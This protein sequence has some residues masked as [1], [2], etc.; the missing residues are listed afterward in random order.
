MIIISINPDL[1]KYLALQPMAFIQGKYLWT[2]LTSMFS[3]IF[4]WHIFANM[5]T[6]IFIGGFVEKIL[7]QKRYLWFYLAAGIIASLFFISLSVL[8]GN[9]VIGERIFG[10]PE[11]F[12]LGA[13]GAIFGLA[14]L[15]TILIPRMKVL[16]FFIVPMPIWMAMVFFLGFFWFLSVYQGLPI[17]NSA[18]LGGFL[19]GI[20]YGL[21]LK[22]KFPRKT[23]YIKRVFS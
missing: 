7:G 3:H 6:L 2:L 22:N 11:L 17:G 23:A 9:S 20:T 19:V 13:S 15:I 21:Y 10:S 8:F 18:H 4:L 5:I 16:V 12:A 1:I 14:G